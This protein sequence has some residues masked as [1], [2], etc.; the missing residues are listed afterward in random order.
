MIGVASQLGGGWWAICLWL[1][2]GVHIDGMSRNSIPLLIEL[3]VFR[4]VLW[5]I[6]SNDSEFDSVLW[7]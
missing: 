4:L 3:S 5:M 6:T 1:N 7:I 2:I